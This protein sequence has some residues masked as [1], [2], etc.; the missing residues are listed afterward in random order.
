MASTCFLFTKLSPAQSR[1]STFDRE[2]LA[3]YS[4]V[5]HFRFLLEGRKFRIFTDHKP[6]IAAMTRVTP[7][8]SARQQR[9]LSFLAE[10]TSN[11]RHTSGHT[12]V[13]A[14]ALSRPPPE[15]I[16]ESAAAVIKTA[17][18]ITKTSPSVLHASSLAFQ[19]EPAILCAADD[20]VRP[21]P[22]TP[23][24]IDF[25][26][27][28]AAQQTSPEV[29]AMS[30]S[31]S[32]QIVSR[33]AGD[34]TILGDISTGTF[35]PLVPPAFRQEVI[36]LLHDVH[37][38]GV[39]ATTR[40]IKASFCWPKMGKDIAVAARVC[41]GCQLGKVHRY[42]KLQPEHIP[43]PRRRFAH[44]H[45]DLV[46]P[47]PSSSGCTHL[48]TIVDRTT[49]WPEAVPVSAT[50]AADCA[51]ALFSGWVQRFG[52][53]AAITSDRGPQFTSA[54][55]AALCRL[56]AAEEDPSPSF[57]SD[58]Q[59]IFAGRAL[60]PTSHHSSPAPQELPEDLLLAKHV[61]VRRDSHAP[62]LAAAY[63]GPF[64]VLERSLRFFKL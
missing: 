30:T 32:L 60:L 51:A 16:K 62:P 18:A 36:R 25:Q 4:A 47:L 45:I 58:L 5:R 35:R 63:D 52:L 14:D 31:P 13:V 19:P 59:G 23:P 50:S 57:L 9:H 53:P 27:V 48:F 6:L 42:V 38:P 40:L 28:A 61:L 54:V 2:L 22:P 43:V 26:A 12:N 34:T 55:W 17:P 24:P 41:M 56:L 7:P 44:L 29:A 64:L 33:P 20:G 3:A 1:Y 39:R 11:L 10:F 46:G 15:K 8:L 49:R 37:H 21:P